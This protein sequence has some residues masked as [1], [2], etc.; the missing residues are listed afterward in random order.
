M[1]RALRLIA[2]LAAGAAAMYYLDPQAGRRRRALARDKAVAACHDVERYAKARSR[3]AAD[4]VRGAVARTRSRLSGRTVGDGQLRDRIR[5]R[6]GHVIARPA[7]VE[8]QVRAGRVTLL[9]GVGAGELEPLLDAVARMRGV[10]AV[11]HRLAEEAGT[12]TGAPH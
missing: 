5:A 8:V 4:R 10:A 9:G 12:G 6:L 2:S 3:R 7:A 11:E 1:N